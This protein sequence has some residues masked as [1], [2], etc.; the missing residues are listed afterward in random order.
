MFAGRLDREA[1]TGALRAVVD[2]HE[3]LRVIFERGWQCAA[4]HSVAA[5]RRAVHTT[6]ICAARRTT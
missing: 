6:W 3:S 5:R 4:V 1:L 2:R